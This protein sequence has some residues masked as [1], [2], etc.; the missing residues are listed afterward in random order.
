[1]ILSSKVEVKEGPAIKIKKSSK[2]PLVKVEV[3]DENNKIISSQVQIQPEPQS[4]T[5]SSIVQVVGGNS[6]PSNVISSIVE[7]RTN[8]NEEDAAIEVNGNNIDKPEYDFLHR[9]P[10]EVVDETY[11]VRT[12][13]LTRHAFVLV[14]TAVRLRVLM[15]FI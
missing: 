2:Q 3:R 10:S 1:M 11:K 4:K 12:I 14:K 9:Q 13:F 15:A 6:S 8:G 5:L 7:I